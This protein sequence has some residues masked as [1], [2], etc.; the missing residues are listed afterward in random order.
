MVGIEEI[1]GKVAA[2]IEGIE[3]AAIFEPIAVAALPPA[4]NMTVSDDGDVRRPKGA[5][6]F[7]RLDDFFVGKAIVEHAIDGVA[8]IDGKAGDV[9]AA[10]AGGSGGRESG[11]VCGCGDEWIGWWVSGLMGG[12]GEV[13]D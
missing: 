6:G 1:N 2:R 9:A 7:E 12:G 11:T 13:V 5:L 4:N 10:G 3:V 8:E